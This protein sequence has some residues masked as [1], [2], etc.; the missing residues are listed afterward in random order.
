MDYFSVINLECKE[1]KLLND[2]KEVMTKRKND[3]LFKRN[4]FL[5]L[6]FAYVFTF[7]LFSQ[8]PTGEW[9]LHPL[10]HKSI[11]VAYGNNIVY[12]AFENAILEY[13]IATGD[14]STWTSVNALS[15]VGIKCIYFDDF[16]KGLFIGYN[17]GNI[18]YI[19]N[20]KVTNIPAIV[21]SNVSGLKSVNKFISFQNK[22]YA[23]TGF[24]IVVIDP[25]KLEVSDTYYPT[26]TNTS[27][28]DIAFNQDS[29]FALTST[30][31]LKASI[32][33]PILPDYG[34]WSIEKRV[35]TIS[36]TSTYNDIAFLND[37]LYILKRNPTYAFDSVFCVKSN[38]FE[39]ASVSDYNLEL[40]SIEVKNNELIINSDG[41]ILVYQKVIDGL[42][43]VSNFYSIQG[44]GVVNSAILS[45]NEA[46]IGNYYGG[47][48]H[49]KNGVSNVIEL[50]GPPKNEFYRMDY[51][52]GKIAIAGGGLD[53]KFMTYSHSGVYTFDNEQ[54]SLA[55]Q[56]TDQTWKNLDIWDY[57]SVAINPKNENQLAVG[58][59]SPTPLSILENGKVTAVFDG[60]NSEIEVNSENKSTLISNVKYDKK[61]NLWLTNSFAS[62]PLKVLKTDG[63]WQKFAISSSLSNYVIKNLEIDE[64]G[65]KWMTATGIG[66]IAFNDNE[67]FDDPSDD[68]VKIINNGDFT[69]A[70]PTNDV[71]TIAI[72]LNNDIWIGTE[73]GFAIL[74]NTSN[75]FD[76]QAGEYNVQRIKLEFEGNVEYL[77]GN[78][79]ISAIEVDGG[80]RKW[81][82]TA[83]AG[84][85]LLSE[86]GT[87]IIE[88]FT[89]DNSPLISNTIMDLQLN[90]QTGELFIITDKGLIS[91]RTDASEGD[92]NYSDVKIFPNP[93]QPG[94]AGL[95]TIKGIQYDSDV[96]ITDIAGNLVYKTT[97]YGG[98]ATWNGK[99]LDG[100]H[101][102][103]GVYLIWTSPNEGKGRKVG[104]VVVIN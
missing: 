37:E 31:L 86:D 66:L 102:S 8:I 18:D 74:Y 26:E 41:G 51:F 21:L 28:I 47:L 87:E 38:G 95:I 49:Y 58:S 43:T 42:Y 52:N 48:I 15:D 4:Y 99:T 19:K 32:N 59:Y 39:V 27:I 34:Q 9:R 10:S 73:S 83:N 40:Y 29:I 61:G 45:S 100:N 75:I 24:G 69:G 82:G 64:N 103:T 70:L 23:S 89:T 93:V 97:S 78:T 1:T 65:Y 20:N 25:I 57:V 94:F 44:S 53:S 16:S 33:N 55:D 88:S 85:F 6:V 104:K 62:F 36:D 77:L 50:Q 17:N 14:K 81:I 68:E 76:A 7:P 13:D 90:H 12:C 92:P 96:K 71:T 79:S 56:N 60:D 30:F 80:N 72:D 11:D 63:S 54:W 5:S 2:Y 22:V 67:T 3:N 101:V 91:Y 46:Y 84:L 35:P 98:T